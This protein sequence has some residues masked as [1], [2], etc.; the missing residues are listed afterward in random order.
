[1][2]RTLL[3]ILIPPVPLLAAIHILDL[4][5]KR[6]PQYDWK[7][8]DNATVLHTMSSMGS[9]QEPVKPDGR[10]A[11]LEAG[12]KG[13]GGSS[14]S[15]RADD[16][17]RRSSGLESSEADGGGGLIRGESTSKAGSLQSKGHGRRRAAEGMRSKQ[18]RSR[19]SSRRASHSVVRNPDLQNH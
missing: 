9:D 12:R 13:L 8:V 19:A 7:E 18:R 15:Q 17:I 3:P 16:S 2:T 6:R 4:Q 10:E 11:V 14:Q 1:M 5:E